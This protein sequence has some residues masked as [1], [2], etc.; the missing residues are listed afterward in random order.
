MRPRLKEQFRRL[1]RATGSYGSFQMKEDGV[2]D[3]YI[4]LSDYEE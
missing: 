3:N 2:L 1:E 4:P